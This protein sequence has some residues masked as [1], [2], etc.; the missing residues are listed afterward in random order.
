MRKPTLR[1]VHRRR[2]TAAVASPWGAAAAAAALLC[3]HSAIPCAMA[4]SDET[5]ASGAAFFDDDGV[6]EAAHVMEIGSEQVAPPEW[7]AMLGVLWPLFIVTTALAFSGLLFASL[8]SVCCSR[9]GEKRARGGTPAGAPDVRVGASR[10]RRCQSRTGCSVPRLSFKVL[11]LSVN[12]VACVLRLVWLVDPEGWLGFYARPMQRLLLR[13][14]QQCLFVV[15]LLFLVMWKRVCY[16]WAHN[17]VRIKSVVLVGRH[18]W[19]LSIVITVL[20]GGGLV[21]EALAWGGIAE[22]E[23][24]QMIRLLFGIYMLGFVGAGLF[25][26]YRLHAIFKNRSR[27]GPELARRKLQRTVRM[28]AAT[29]LSFTV[30]FAIVVS[31]GGMGPYLWLSYT[32]F[33]RAAEAFTSAAVVLAV[34]PTPRRLPVPLCCATCYYHFRARKDGEAI[35]REVMQN[36]YGAM[37][38]V[39]GE[40]DKPEQ[41]SL[42]ASVRRTS[43]KVRDMIDHASHRH[44]NISPDSTDGKEEQP[45]DKRSQRARPQV[46]GLAPSRLSAAEVEL[47][48]A[49]GPSDAAGDRSRG[50]A[51]GGAVELLKY[52]VNKPATHSS[53]HKKHHRGHGAARAAVRSARPS[54][55]SVAHDSRA[56]PSLAST[57]PAKL[58]PMGTADQGS[59]DV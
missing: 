18:K 50:P 26:S 30:F 22:K 40:F 46:P 24:Q 9:P 4:Q 59:E 15:V 11:V 38:D 33:L 28:L 48:V 37:V 17:E 14:P 31:R 44:L 7:K 34:V 6:A 43:H 45:P 55:A 13:L 19:F 42:A 8:Q 53:H 5:S 56:R 1:Q 57:A 39:L 52:A 12:A 27:S 54:R 51:D 32:W 10:A 21:C 58:G 23:A 2:S 25:Y 47:T 20:T 35:A 3:S 36:A 41:H 49:D 16:A 29:F